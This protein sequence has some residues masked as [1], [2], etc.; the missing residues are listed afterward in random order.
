MELFWL[1]II[2]FNVYLFYM[3][4]FILAASRDERHHVH[5]HPSKAPNPKFWVLL[6]AFFFRYSYLL[7][8]AAMF[9]LGFSTVNLLNFVYIVL[10]LMFFSSG[11]NVLVEPKI[12]NSKE[13]VT[14]TTFSRKYWFIIVYYTLICIILKYSYFLFFPDDLMV[15]LQ[16]TG[17]NL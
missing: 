11:E 15:P 2:I 3:I 16:P 12:R 10:F 6:L 17:I 7:T 13:V 1:D 9:F 14:L 4:T 8:L 5:Q